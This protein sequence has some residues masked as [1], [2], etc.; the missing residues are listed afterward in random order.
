MPKKRGRR[1]IKTF[2]IDTCIA[3]DY[4]TNRNI[5]TV[6]LL[7]LIKERGWRCISSTFLAM[8]MADYKKEDLFIERA[9]SKK[10]E[11]RRILRQKDKKELKSADFETTIDWFEDF[12]KRYRKIDMYDFLQD[13]DSWQLA[14]EISFNSNLNA[15]DV[16]HLT[17][18][19]WAALGGHCD[20]FITGDELLNK[21]GKKIIE[22]YKLKSVLKI[23]TVAE[24]KKKYFKKK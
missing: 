10:W 15:P 1:K 16:I 20:V 14:Q 21:E 9:R 11:F 6:M 12:K 22:Q 23:M 3:I 13:K 18:A 24:V 4:A 5:E 17:S 7:E 8:E 2:Y 19:I